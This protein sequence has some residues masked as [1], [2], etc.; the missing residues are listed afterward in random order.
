M[1]PSTWIETELKLPMGID[2]TRKMADEVCWLRVVNV[3]FEVLAFLGS[4][5]TLQSPHWKS[6]LT[7]SF[8]MLSCKLFMKPILTSGMERLRQK[9][10]P[11][12]MS[13][14]QREHGRSHYQ[15]L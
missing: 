7:S 6:R 10:V 4:N 12:G 11:I 8:S 9:I 5:M 14:N 2:A 15:P 1:L 13:R 3:E